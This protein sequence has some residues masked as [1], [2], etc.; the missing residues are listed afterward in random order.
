MTLA[1][2]WAQKQVDERVNQHPA[3][4]FSDEKCFDKLEEEKKEMQDAL[5]LYHENPS[6]ENLKALKT[7]F[8]DELFAIICLAN[9]LKIDLEECFN[10]MMEKNKNRAKNGYKKEEK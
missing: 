4:Y 10:L 8:G 1:F 2:L 6:D 5:A 7:E 3:W 9:K